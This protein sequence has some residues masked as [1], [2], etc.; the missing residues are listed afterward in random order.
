MSLIK[1]VIFI[2]AN[3]ICLPFSIAQNISDDKNISS[4]QYKLINPEIV[5]AF[6]KFNQHKLFWFNNGEQYYLLRI[7]LRNIIDSSENA[8]LEKNKYH[9]TD[10]KERINSAFADKDSLAAM[11]LDKIFTDAAIAYA[12]DIYQGS[13][14][15]DWVNNDEI[16]KKYEGADNNYLLNNFL[17]VKTPGDLQTFFNYIESDNKEYAALKIELKDQSKSDNDLKKLQLEI[18]LNLFRWIHHFHFDKYIIVNITSAT[19]RYYTSDSLS[20]TM[21]VVVGKPSTKTPRF[22]TYC[23]QIIIYP[24]WNVPSS[25]ALNEL[26]P[27]FKKNP[28]HMDELNM[29][30]MNAAGKII[31]HHKLNWKSYNKS[32]FPF[33]IR[34]S[35]GCDNSLGVIKFNLTSPYSVYLHDTNNKNVFMSGFRFYSHGCIR[36]EEPIVLANKFL[37]MKI[38]SKYLE[39]CLKDQ[40]P[41]PIKLDKPVPVFVVYIPVEMINS[42]VKYYNDVYGLLKTHLK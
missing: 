23:D 9:F 1:H 40:I 30:L 32:Y 10:L 34:Q 31:D 16:S 4:N 38:D 37:N 33:R 12:K 7:K 6:Y 2:A 5:S 22:A 28:N 41:V 17:A 11:H 25:I 26:L 20:G 27:K 3:F 36:I 24:Y 35:T 39:S 18:S 15:S 21:K 42:K 13:N 8:G 14:V 19:L 29:L